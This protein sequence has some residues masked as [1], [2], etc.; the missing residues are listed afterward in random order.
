MEMDCTSGEDG[1]GGEATDRYPGSASSICP[2]TYRTAA[3]LL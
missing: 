2:E 3:G 1:D